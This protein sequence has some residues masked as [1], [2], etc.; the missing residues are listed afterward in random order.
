MLSL[1][2]LIVIDVDDARKVI[3][4]CPP[5]GSRVGPCTLW[6]TTCVFELELT[7]AKIS[8]CI[9]IMYGPCVRLGADSYFFLNRDLLLISPVRASLG[10][11][12][13]L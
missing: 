6:S 2:V 9:S 12:C 5:V 1:F 4:P 13:E 3:A 7:C 8:C 10:F 11:P